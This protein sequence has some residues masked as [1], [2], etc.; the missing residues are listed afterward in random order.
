MYA[1]RSY[2][3]D[4]DGDLSFATLTIDLTDSGIMAPDD[5]DALVYE[6]ARNNFV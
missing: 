1:I 5:N 2:Y 6:R 3:E 4:G